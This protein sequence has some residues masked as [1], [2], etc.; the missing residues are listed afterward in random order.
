M[1]MNF[2][3]LF[4]TMNSTPECPDSTSKCFCYEHLHTLDTL[5][6]KR[7]AGVGSVNAHLPPTLMNLCV[8]ADEC[9]TQEKNRHT[10]TSSLLFSQS[11]VDCICSKKSLSYETVGDFFCLQ[12]C[13]CFGSSGG[14]LGHELSDFADEV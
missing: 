13:P 8:I 9:T 4:L 14:I 11:S 7:R 2:L 10:K 3:H 12:I 1:T 6:L 5:H